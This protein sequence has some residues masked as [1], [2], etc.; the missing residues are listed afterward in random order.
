MFRTGDQFDASYKSATEYML[1]C[2]SCF[3][4]V[5]FF[6]LFH[7]FSMFRNVFET[8]V[9]YNGIRKHWL[10]FFRLSNTSFSVNILITIADV[11]KVEYY[12]V[13]LFE[14]YK[15]YH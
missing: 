10:H 15:R 1:L 14:I 6:Y 2:T 3:I 4:L 12:G 11:F 9:E 5:L 8:T 7:F 13:F